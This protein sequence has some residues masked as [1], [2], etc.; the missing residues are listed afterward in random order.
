MLL[1]VA[2]ESRTFTHWGPEHWFVIAA[3][4]VATLV[5]SIVLRCAAR[6]T[7]AALVTRIV[8]GGLAV[9]LTLTY[10]WGQVHRIQHGYWRLDESL[11]LHL[12]DLAGLA[13]VAALVGAERLRGAN[14]VRAAAAGDGT[15][16][17]RGIGVW[18]WC[19]ELAYFWVLG[20]TLQALVTPDVVGSF[21]DATCIR[22][23]VHHCGMITSVLVMMFGL[24]LRPAP[25][26]FRRAWVVT[27]G[28]A[29][30]VGVI[31]AALRAAG[32]DANYMYLCA[33]PRADT[34]FNLLGPWPWYLLT[35]LAVGTVMLALLYLPHWLI[36][37]RR[38]APH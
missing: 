5:P 21:P 6:T 17:S 23:F 15:S 19:F 3:T 18:Q 25:G 20:G 30:L 38:G 31:N 26:A 28:A 7:S 4:A 1:L 16:R 24:G 10:A 12:C 8:C 32:I 2:A 13:T 11:P 33:R 29:V 22:F 14:R 34:L 27:L 37:R 35:L 9:A 36:D